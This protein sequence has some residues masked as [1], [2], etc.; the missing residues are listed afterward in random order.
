MDK[1]SI[2][3]LMEGFNMRIDRHG[4]SIF[5]FCD[6]T[7]FSKNI[8]LDTIKKYYEIFLCEDEFEIDMKNYYTIVTIKQYSN[9]LKISISENSQR[10]LYPQPILHHIKSDKMLIQIF[11][12]FINILEFYNINNDKDYYPENGLDIKTFNFDSEDFYSCVYKL[13]YI[14]KNKKS[15]RF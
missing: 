14:E 11:K 8:P 6:G 1:V 2:I 9:V 12:E 15:A 13:P 7:L 10:Q 3:I 4:N 5:L